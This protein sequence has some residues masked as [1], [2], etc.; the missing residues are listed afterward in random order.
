MNRRSRML[1]WIA[2][3]IAGLMGGGFLLKAIINRPLNKLDAQIL[4]LNT[5]LSGL[6]KERQAFLTADNEIQAYAS[7]LFATRVEEAESRLGALLTAQIVRVGLREADFTRIPVGRRRLPGAEELGWTVQGEGTLPQLMDLLYLLQ[8]EPRLHR[9]EGLSLAPVSEPGRSRARFRYLTLVLAPS[10]ELPKTNQTVELSL[11]GPAR[12]R[13]DAITQRDFFRPFTPQ[14]ARLAAAPAEPPPSGEPARPDLRVVSLSAW[15][16]QP[17]VHLF[18]P[19]QQRTL[20]R[21]PG[22]ALLD[23]EVATVDYRP[24]PLP[25]KPGLLSYSRLIWRCDTNFWAVEAGQS[26]SERRLLGIEE[27]PAALRP[28]PPLPNSVFP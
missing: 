20:V 7:R 16:G 24:L 6:N 15:D 14:E 12:R 9:I 8:S 1:A 10:P 11:D 21:R 22:E 17:E 4:Q 27:L 5:R 26:L 13:Y 19:A 23:G 18:D 3:T 28:V 2:V 25:G